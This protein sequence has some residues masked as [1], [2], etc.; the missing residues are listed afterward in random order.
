MINKYIPLWKKE[1]NWK[2]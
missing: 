2:W 1:T